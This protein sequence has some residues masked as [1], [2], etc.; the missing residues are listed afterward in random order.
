MGRREEVEVREREEWS[1]PWRVTCYLNGEI[2]A[3]VFP[4]SAVLQPLITPSTLGRGIRGEESLQT[5]FIT[6]FYPGLVFVVYLLSC[7]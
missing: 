4:H 6:S 5:P 7:V 3:Q 1:I 2:I